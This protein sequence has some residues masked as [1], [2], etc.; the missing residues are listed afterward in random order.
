MAFGTL[1]VDPLLTQAPAE[2]FVKAH[3]TGGNHSSGLGVVDQIPVGIS[4][5]A[6][7]DA[8]EGGISHFSPLVCWD[9]Y[10]CGAA[11]D[12][13][14]AQVRGVTI[15]QCDWDAVDSAVVEAIVEVADC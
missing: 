8:L 1:E 2:S 14:M 11:E 9:V 13:E 4:G 12:A 6:H 5:V 15:R 3:M 10:I 7:Q